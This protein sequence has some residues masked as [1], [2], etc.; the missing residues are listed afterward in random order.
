MFAHGIIKKIL[1][2][3][4]AG[5]LQSMLGIGPRMPGTISCW[6]RE[7]KKMVNVLALVNVETGQVAP[8]AILPDTGRGQFTH[9]LLPTFHKDFEAESG[10]KV[11]DWLP[12]PED[13]HYLGSLQELTVRHVFDD[14]GCPCSDCADTSNVKEATQA[15]GVA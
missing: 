4:L 6:D 10:E 3:F 12:R 14:A 2:D 7:T 15:R 1:L 9:R 11:S 5:T 8:M 13:R